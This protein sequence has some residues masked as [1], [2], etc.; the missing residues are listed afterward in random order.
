LLKITKFSRR[1]LEKTLAG[2]GH[3]VSV[4]NDGGVAW[5][6]LQQADAPLLAILDIMMPEMDGYEVCRKVRQ[7]PAAIQPY[8]ILLSALSSK[9]DLVT[10]IQA[11]ANEYLTKPFHSAELRVR[12]EGGVRMIELQRILSDRVA[13]LEVALSQVKQLQ[14][15]LPICSYCH[16][17]RDDL[18]YW[19]KID[20]YLSDRID[21]E[22]SHSICPN[23]LERVTSEA[24]VSKQEIAESR[25]TE[26]Q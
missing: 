10:G 25:S 1:I 23:C 16:K 17:V 26:P 24:R 21:V 11:G 18:N 15:L 4:A 12:V 19:Q 22:F 14:G 13:E 2:W 3:E 5:D 6:M 7:Q 20:T 9:D 8:L